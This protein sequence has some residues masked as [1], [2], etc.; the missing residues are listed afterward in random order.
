M[1]DSG[2]VVGAAAAMVSVRGDATV[3]A[4]PEIAVFSVSVS[5]RDR[6]RRATLATLSRRNDQFL[7]V[8]R[9]FGT[10]VEKAE[11]SEVSVYPELRRGREEKVRWYRGTIRTRLTVADLAVAGELVGRISDVELCVIAGPWWELRPDSPVYREAR[12]SAA[13]DAVTRAAEYA[14]AVGGRLTGLV[15]LADTGL[16][17]GGNPVRMLAAACRPGVPDGGGG[18]G[19]DRH[20]ARDAG[21]A[22]ERRGTVHDDAAP[23]A[24]RWRPGAIRRSPGLHSAANAPP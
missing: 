2:D 19:R 20:G 3:E 5:A 7:A 8:V 16:G 21:R 6:D 14:E 10:A 24:A 12:V 22:G 23:V 13:R 1:T 18:S 4:D 11:T 9:S 15:E 17:G